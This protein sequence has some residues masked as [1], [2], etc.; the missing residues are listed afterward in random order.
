ME[1]IT[2]KGVS[3]DDLISPEPLIRLQ[4]EKTLS[5]NA[6]ILYVLGKLPSQVLALL[7]QDI[8]Q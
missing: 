3:N 6:G 5:Y 1:L 4:A 7:G 2:L 8:Q